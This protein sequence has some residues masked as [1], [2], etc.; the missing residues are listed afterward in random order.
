MTVTVAIVVAAARNGVIG[1]D[2]KLL[3]RLK[4][5][6]RRFRSLTIGKPV[7]MGRKTF[8]SIG[9]PLPD[10]TSIV[11]S[12]NA[13]FKPDG[14]LVAR[15]IEEALERAADVAAE[16]GVTEVMIAGGSEIYAL[17]LARADR[18]YLTEVDLEPAGDAFFAPVD[19]LQFREV[20]RV[21]H[22]AGHDD[23]AAFSFIDYVR[24]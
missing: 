2:N 1:K 4:S 12:R 15:S 13:G 10:R 16:T 17:T 19:P 6:L 23:E 14:V 8:E 18:I 5:D 21:S 7:V 20:K 22:A 3:W 24:R 11:V 9:R